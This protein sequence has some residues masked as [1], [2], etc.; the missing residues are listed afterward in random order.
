MSVADY[1]LAGLA[2]LACA[3]LGGM[4]WLLGMSTYFA[5]TPTA[6]HASDSRKGCAGFV[7]CLLAIAYLFGVLFNGDWGWL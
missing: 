7:L 2:L 1:I 4:F 5:P 6:E 3:S